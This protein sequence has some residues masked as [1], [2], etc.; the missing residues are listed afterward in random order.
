[1]S[2]IRRWLVESTDSASSSLSLSSSWLHHHRHRVVVVLLLSHV[3]SLLLGACA[4]RTSTFVTIHWQCLS[5]SVR[6][7]LSL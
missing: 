3:S 5:A 7:E 2:L 4:A 1:M 6:S